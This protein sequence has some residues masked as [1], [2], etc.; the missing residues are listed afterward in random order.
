M[1]RFRRRLVS[2]GLL[3]AS[4]ADGRTANVLHH[5]W[6]PQAQGKAGADADRRGLLNVELGRD[7]IGSAEADTADIAGQAVRVLR[8]ELN[9][10]GAIGLVDAHRP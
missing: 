1:C 9:G 10:V 3:S 4:R 5:P 6:P 2:C 8:N 7:L